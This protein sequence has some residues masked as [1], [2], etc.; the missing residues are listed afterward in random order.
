VNDTQAPLIERFG[1]RVRLGMVGGG[2]DSVIGETH[3]VAL[4]IDGL[5]ELVAGAMSIDPAVSQATGRADLLAPDRVHTDYRAMA[6]AEAE[7]DDPIDAVVVATPPQTHLGV[8]TEFLS[9]GIDVICE[10]PL[11]KNLE[12]ADRLVKI[13]DESGRLLVLTHCY[14][15]YPMVREARA[16]VRSGRLGPIRLVEARFAGGDP[17]VAREP[18]DPSQRHW[19]FRPESMGPAAILGEVG[20]HAHNIVGYVTGLTVTSVSAQ[21]DTIAAR[22]DV[23]DNAYLN[24]RFDSGAV[25]RIWSSY[26]AIG[27][28]HGLGFQIIG[29]DASLSWSQEDP[30]RLRVAP[31]DAPAY[32]L[33]R[34]MDATSADGLASAR[35]RPGHPEGYALAFANIY[36]DYATARM[37]LDLGEPSQATAAL[38]R[39]PTVEDGRHVMSLIEAAAASAEAKGDWVGLR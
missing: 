2:L 12:E 26:V 15:G 7:R 27:N 18:E 23:Y 35:F 31:I 6:A 8:A 21:M 4:R 37:L 36:R 13:V 3:R 16:L 9:R 29:D 17:G 19:R 22:R 39:L 32:Y 1:R 11:T 25:G 38:D 24:V 10:K 28:E 34:G 5:C 14:T 30:E 33:T 20:S